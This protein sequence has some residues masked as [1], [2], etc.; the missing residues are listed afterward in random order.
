MLLVALNFVSILIL[1]KIVTPSIDNAQACLHFVFVRVLQENVFCMDGLAATSRRVAVRDEDSAD[2]IQI[3][4]APKNYVVIAIAII[5]FGR[6]YQVTELYHW[7]ML[8]SFPVTHFLFDLLMSFRVIDSVFE[9]L[10]HFVLSLSV[11]I[12]SAASLYVVTLQIINF[13]NL[14]DVLS[15]SNVAL[16]YILIVSIPSW[17]RIIPIGLLE[18]PF[19]SSQNLRLASV[20]GNH[21]TA[22]TTGTEPLKIT[23]LR[24]SN[25]NATSFRKEPLGLCLSH[26]IGLG[27]N[28]E[29]WLQTTVQMQ[30]ERIVYWMRGVTFLLFDQAVY[31]NF[32]LKNDLP[33]LLENK[34]VT[35]ERVIECIEDRKADN[36]S[37]IYFSWDFWHFL[38]LLPKLGGFDGSGYN[39]NRLLSL[40]SIPGCCDFK[41]QE[42]GRTVFGDVITHKGL[43]WLDKG[44][45]GTNIG[46]IELMQR[47]QTQEFLEGD[48]FVDLMMVY[49]EKMNRFPCDQ[50]DLRENISGARQELVRDFEDVVQN[51]KGEIEY[52]SWI[53]NANSIKSKEK[54]SNICPLTD[55]QLRETG[56]I[57]KEFLKSLLMTEPKIAYI[58]MSTYLTLKCLACTPNI[59]FYYNQ[60]S[61]HHSDIIHELSSPDENGFSESATYVPR[62]TRLME[63]QPY[64][65]G[66][67]LMNQ[68]WAPRKDNVDKVTDDEE[69]I[70]DSTNFVKTVSQTTFE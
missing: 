3:W 62:N 2:R 15:L 47:H 50:N 30:D 21:G 14:E 5:L 63:D 55:E 26:K 69:P 32:C 1:E 33:I 60:C 28:L 66:R 23:L 49:Y 42:W 7:L 18:L 56:H 46:W 16:Y 52:W 12:S 27:T 45:D 41:F 65:N 37:S 44:V 57:T 19:I 25:A 40:F 13:D 64:Y 34:P 70:F 39:K 4:G 22:L 53:E 67:L 51:L 29:S 11:Q 6:L 9:K 10:L 38:G 35:L 36:A 54:F 24:L 58:L 68:H 31:V 48:D 43:F 59:M 61:L 20:T 17:I 8:W